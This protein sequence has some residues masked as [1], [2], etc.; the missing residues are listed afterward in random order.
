MTDMVIRET[1]SQGIPFNV[2]F[3]DWPTMPLNIYA[4]LGVTGGTAG[5]VKSGSVGTAGTDVYSSITA[6]QAELQARLRSRL[7]EILQESIEARRIFPDPV[8]A[9]VDLLGSMSGD[10]DVWREIIE[11]PYG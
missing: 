9:L 3:S 4:S 11:E 10:Y 8:Q 1:V 2:N 6:I 7:P 5:L